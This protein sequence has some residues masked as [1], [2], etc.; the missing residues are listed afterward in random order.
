MTCNRLTLWLMRRAAL[1]DTVTLVN[2]V[3]ETR[4]VPE[5]L[6]PQCRP[7]PIARCLIELLDSDEARAAQLAAM[8]MTMQAL[9]EGGEAPGLRAARSVL[10]RIGT[11][12]G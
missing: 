4:A 6:R 10:A 2:L 1:I 9:G 12:S 7:D 3:S 8:R 11:V 5:I